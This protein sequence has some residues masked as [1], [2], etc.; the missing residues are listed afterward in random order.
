ML[1]SQEAWVRIP[2]LSSFSLPSSSTWLRTFCLLT[3]EY[4]L[5]AWLWLKT[6]MQFLGTYI[7]C[8]FPLREVQ[9][10]ILPKLQ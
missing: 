9:S 1:V 10:Y 5:L 4:V 2:L 7:R 3:H 8:R 6:F